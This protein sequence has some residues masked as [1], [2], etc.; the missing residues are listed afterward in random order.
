MH[1]HSFRIGTVRAFLK[2]RHAVIIG[3][4]RQQLKYTADEVIRFMQQQVFIYLYTGNNPDT[5][6]GV[7]NFVIISRCRRS[8]AP[9][10]AFCGVR[11]FSP[12]YGCNF[13]HSFQ[14]ASGG[15]CTTKACNI[16]VHPLCLLASFLTCQL[17]QF[18]A[19]LR[20]HILM[21]LFRALACVCAIV[22]LRRQCASA[23][24]N[25]FCM[26]L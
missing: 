8:V 2:I 7:F 12:C 9:P 6:F 21:P 15:C 22:R 17:R 23:Y 1:G 16:I 25:L 13:F 11:H 10:V 4:K 18:L 14:Q 24:R 20:V 19:C 3:C 5:R 26:P